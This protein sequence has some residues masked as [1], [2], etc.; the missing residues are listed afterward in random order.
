MDISNSLN[1][2]A[3]FILSSSL[4]TLSSSMISKI[5]SYSQ[6]IFFSL[7]TLPNT[8]SFH[9]LKSTFKVLSL[10]ATIKLEVPWKW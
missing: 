9:L 3:F 5:Q 7:P 4:K 10:L 8:S 2:F 6:R 1:T